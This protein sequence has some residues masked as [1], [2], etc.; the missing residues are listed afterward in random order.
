[1]DTFL[2]GPRLRAAA[3]AA[4][5][6]LGGCGTAVGNRGNASIGPVPA[7]DIDQ[8]YAMAL[9]DAA[10]FEERDVLPLNGAEAGSD[11]T[12]LV[13]TLGRDSLP[14]GEMTTAEGGYVWVT[15]VPEVRDSC[16]GWADADKAMR[17][18]QLLG[19][20][21]A[22]PVQYFVEMRVPAAGMFRP[23]ANP[24][25]TTDTLCTPGQGGWECALDF[26]AGVSGK[27]V[28]FMVDQAFS[29]W[30]K[31]NGYPAA[32]TGESPRL[33][34]PWT[35]LGY[36]YNWHPG[37]PRYGAS[38]YVIDPGTRVTVTSVARIADYCRRR[39]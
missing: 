24:D 10:I 2:S 17:L 39:Q 30:K 32:G 36:T 34:Y 9:D 11:G 37:S 27:H 8:L 25:I 18:R 38:E 16:G 14:P 35:R 1:M 29:A 6:L 26:P 21:P 31:P 15:L 33:G 20:Q 28:R 12:V 4:L 19:L 5:V 23:T 3:G 22:S 7:P 13:V